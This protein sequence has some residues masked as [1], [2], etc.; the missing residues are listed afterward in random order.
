MRAENLFKNR[1]KNIVPGKHVYVFTECL[2]IKQV[3]MIR[4]KNIIT[5][6]RLT[7]GTLRKS[8]LTATRHQEDNL[9]KAS[10]SLSLFPIK[11]NA[12]LEGHGVL[13]NK[14]RTITQNQHKQWKQQETM[15]QQQQNHC[16][17]MDSRPRHWGQNASYWHQS[18]ALDSV[19]F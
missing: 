12:K 16:L 5:H 14:T 3:S 10:S 9:S 4:K 18:L 15:N 1:C 13:D 6:C 7:Q 19:L 17:I 2:N 8:T 11:I